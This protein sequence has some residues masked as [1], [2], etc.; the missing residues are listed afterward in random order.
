MSTYHLLVCFLTWHEIGEVRGD[1]CIVR[2]CM[3]IQ[4]QRPKEKML[5]EQLD[6]RNSNWHGE[7]AEQIVSIP[8]KVGDPSKIIQVGT[9]L[10]EL[11]R[12][13]LID[14]LRGNVDDFAWTAIDMLSILLEVIT[15]KLNVNPN[16][17]SV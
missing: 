11:A 1:Q 3:T 7:P 5:D 15:H 10:D 13:L 14:F 12:R 6:Q 2:D 4:T 8:L 17:K 16:L 9:L